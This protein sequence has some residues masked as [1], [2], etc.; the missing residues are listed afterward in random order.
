M[1]T[2]H[3]I[4]KLTMNM[5]QIRKNLHLNYVKLWYEDYKGEE[6]KNMFPVE[7]TNKIN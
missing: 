1:L 7:Q 3:I 2:E 6:Y 5:Y 4:S